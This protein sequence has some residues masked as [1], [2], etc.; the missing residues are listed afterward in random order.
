MADEEPKRKP[1]VGVSPLAQIML[2]WRGQGVKFTKNFSL[3]EFECRCGKCSFTLV[4]LGHVGRLQELREKL[5]VL[6]QR[7]V[8]IKIHSAYRCPAYNKNVGGAKESQH[9]FGTATD[10]EAENVPIPDLH[11]LCCQI[12]DGVG[13]YDTFVHADSR[14]Y[15]ARWDLRSVK[16]KKKGT[17]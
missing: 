14:G 4:D 12:F 15:E 1:S 9:T 7:D 6:Y 11:R 5:C 13:L 17:P 10:I 2:Y 16:E 8:K 3:V